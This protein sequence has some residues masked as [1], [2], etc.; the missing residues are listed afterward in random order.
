[1]ASDRPKPGLKTLTAQ[2]MGRV[3]RPYGDIVPPIHPL[4][5]ASRNR[6]HKVSDTVNPP[7]PSRIIVRR[8]DRSD[9]LAQ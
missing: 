6:P 5:P 2:G 4:I 3:A 9:R 8:P 7:T 1:M